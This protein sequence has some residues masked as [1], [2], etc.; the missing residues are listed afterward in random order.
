MKS[1]LTLFAGLDPKGFLNIVISG[2][3]VGMDI[4]EQ[5][6]NS[7][8]NGKYKANY[9]KNIEASNCLT[10][11]VDEKLRKE[12]EKWVVLMKSGFEESEI[13]YENLVQEFKGEVRLESI[14]YNELAKVDG[15]LTCCSVLF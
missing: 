5:F 10:L 14:E 12:N 6:E 1:F 4:F 3:D 13:V 7:K 8:T 11:E 9:V 15:C 2:C